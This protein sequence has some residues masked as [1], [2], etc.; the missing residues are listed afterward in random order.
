VS[1]APRREKRGSPPKAKGK[2]H[3]QG[4]QGDNGDDDEADDDDDDD[5]DDVDDDITDNG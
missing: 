1:T 2:P 5:D 3:R 4:G